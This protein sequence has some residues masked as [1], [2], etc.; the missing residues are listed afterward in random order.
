MNSYLIITIT[1]RNITRFLH[2]CRDNNIN[3]LQIRNISH[4]KIIIKINQNDYN[5]LKRIKSF[6]KIE[7]IN[8]GGLLK[9]KELINKNKIILICLFIGLIFL[10]LLSNIIFD[11]KIISN[12]LELNN[13]I[14]K[15]LDY[16]GIKK[17][18]FKKNYNEIQKIKSTLL[19]DFKDNI[20]WLE[21]TEVGTKYEVKIVERKK[22][23]KKENYEYSNI[24]AGKSGIIKKIYAEDGQKVVDINTYVNKGDIIISGTIMKGEEEKQYINAKG[25]IYAEIWYDVTIDFPLNYSEKL[26]TNNKVKR[27]YIKLNNKYISNNKYKNFERK[28][29]KKLK[30]NI[31]PFEL[32]IEEEKEVRIINDR[33]SLIEAK[34]KAIE[35]AKE[36][37]LQTLDNDEYIIDEKVLNFKQKN[38]KIELEM[39]FSCLEEISKKETFIPNNKNNE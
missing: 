15:E 8:S 17:Y 12:N 29:I 14:I 28:T 16:Y 26:Y 23:Q 22:K 21:I 4:K 27:L 36:K 25:K 24:V 32:G 13:K 34:N 1:G 11:I 7:I 38:S 37:I 9:Y 30:N 20:E 6:Y 39:F 19:N 2:K 18:K 5:K 3:I 31:V 10:I 35:K 33:Y